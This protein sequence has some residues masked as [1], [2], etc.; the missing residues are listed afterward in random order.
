VLS[1]KGP[2]VGVV[3]FWDHE[4]EV[5]EGEPATHANMTRL[6]PSFSAFVE[7]LVD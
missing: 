2:D 4:K 3:F 6:A 5:D 1:V 7:S